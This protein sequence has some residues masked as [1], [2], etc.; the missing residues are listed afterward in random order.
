MAAQRAETAGRRG[1]AVLAAVAAGGALGA[2]ARLAVTLW[3]PA[4]GTAGFPWGIF[5]VNLSGCALI[6]VLMALIGEGGRDARAPA[7]LRPF[8][9]VGVLGG[10]TTFSAYALDAA[11]L[12]ESGPRAVP[13]AVAYLAG[14]LLGALAA[15]WAGA[16]A[17]RALLAVREG[18]VTR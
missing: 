12:L 6:G 13:A 18:A 11:H 2:V 16:A 7:L 3:L 9:G 5:A 8:L 15:V 1:S 4:R 10:F 17:T 14:T